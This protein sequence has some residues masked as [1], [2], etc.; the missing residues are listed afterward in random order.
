MSP[1]QELALMAWILLVAWTLPTNVPGGTEG[2]FMKS[3]R[4]NHSLPTILALASAGLTAPAWALD[5]IVPIPEPGS[6][7]LALGAIGVAVLVWRN[8]KK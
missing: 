3:S 7:A 6:M 4:S 2:V 8:R 1:E 5:T